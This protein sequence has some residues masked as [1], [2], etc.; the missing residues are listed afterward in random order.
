MS[1]PEVFDVHM[2]M[3]HA[4]TQDPKATTLA[5]CGALDGPRDFTNTLQRVTCVE[6][7]YEIAWIAI[8]RARK[9]GSE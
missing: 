7:L 9:L 2:M 6:C 5:V 1:A 4:V 3:V 8:D